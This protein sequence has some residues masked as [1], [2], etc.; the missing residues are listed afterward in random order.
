MKFMS[1][2]AWAAIRDIAP[3]LCLAS[4]DKE[5]LDQDKRHTRQKINWQILQAG[6]DY[7]P[8]PEAAAAAAE[9]SAML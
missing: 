9:H 4:S 2:R 3:S 1:A 8:Q 5:K 7:I 6:A